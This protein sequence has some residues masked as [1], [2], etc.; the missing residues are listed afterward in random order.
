M[1][2]AGI[3]DPAGGKGIMA[4]TNEL[5][6]NCLQHERAFCTAECPFHL[7]V[8][9]FIGKM[10]QGRFNVAFR[11]YQQAV[12]FPG[13]VSALC[14]EPCRQ[15]CPLRDAGGPISLQRLEKAAMDYARNT[16]PDQYNLPDK[17]KRVAVVGAGV[18]GLACALRLAARK[19]RVTVYERSDRPGGHL[20]GML[21]PEIFLEDIRRQFAY[22]SYDLRLNAEISS[23]ADLPAEAVFV[24]TG[25]GGPGFGLTR[26]GAGAFATAT[27]GVFFGGSLTGA[28]TMRAIADGL[29][30]A[31]AIE[32]YLK[33]GAMNHPEEPGGT[34]LR[35]DCIRVTAGEAV[36]ARSGQAYDREEAVAEAARCLRCACDACH[37]HSPLM[38]YFRKFPRRIT[39]EVEVTLHPS[40]LDGKATLATRLISTCL[41]CGLC[42]EVCP[43]NID[44]GE[45]LLQSHRAMRAQGKMPWAFHEFYLRDMAFANEEAA[46]ARQPKGCAS[47]RFAFF[48]GCQLGASDP[49][50]VRESYRF[51]VEHYPDTALM[52]QCC[53]APAEWAGEEALHRSV[54]ERIS[55]DWAKL[56]RPTVVFACPTCKIM[57]K[58]YLPE[59]PGRFLYPLLAEKVVR[60][61]AALPA[62]TASVFDPC[63]SREEPELQ[64]AVRRLAVDAGFHLAPL[65]MAGRMAECCSYGGQVAVAH[66]PYARHVVQQR[67]GRN[68]HPYLTYCSNCRDVFARAGK[69]TRHILDVVFGLAESGGGRPTVSER[70]ANRLELKR[71][72]L[73]EFWQEEMPM[74]SSGCNLTVAPSL[75]EKLD[76]D[77]ILESDLLA[78]VEHCQQTGQKLFDPGKGT[79][80]GHRPVGHM[81]YWV[82]YRVLPGERYEI[83]NGYG[84]R[85]KIEE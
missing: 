65:P 60:P 46:L 8:R 84:H 63:A 73:R 69:K 81:T 23:L 42:R 85:M 76:R 72:L 15:V 55:A 47:S 68:E 48:P 18:C 50:L 1:A 75:K 67:T 21:P 35:P 32:R 38:S 78:V 80:T 10:Q 70:R 82:E 66:P 58:K 27:P 33:I 29:N 37:R 14:P 83:V 61:A 12:G 30:A 7:D 64:Q 62:E 59:I 11:S 45:F 3:C 22:E 5:V 40:S 57:F 4:Y 54:R 16:M 17:G 6:A 28:D 49:R 34:R 39:E 24:A 53:G 74:P 2:P 51:L 79:F 43:E 20:H 13:I 44:T 19:Y 26:D 36:Q 77:M 31:N 71:Q 41:H 52:L 9:D 25:R 56:G